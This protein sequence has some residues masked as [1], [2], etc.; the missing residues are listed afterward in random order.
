[1]EASL[2]KWILVRLTQTGFVDKS[3]TQVTQDHVQWPALVSA[4]SKFHG[5]LTEK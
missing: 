3:L 5:L 4:L 1:M 2:R